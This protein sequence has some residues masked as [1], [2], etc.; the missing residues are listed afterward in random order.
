[1]E[2]LRNNLNIDFM[3][4]RRTAMIFSG[5]LILIAIL[6]FI[7]MGFNKGIDFEGGVI[8]VVKFSKSVKVQAVRD[9][10][11]DAD[12]KPRVQQ[13]DSPFDMLIRISPDKK[14]KLELDKNAATQVDAGGVKTKSHALAVMELLRNK[15]DQEVK[16]TRQEEVGPQIG[17]ELRDQGGIAILIALGA[18]LVYVWLRFEKRFALGSIFALMHDVIIVTGVFS[19][20][21][22]EFDLTVLAAI[23]AVIGYS[24]NDT[25]VVF[26]RIREN[27]RKMRKG[28]PVEI[29]N[30]SLNQT[31][32][33]TLMTS[34]TTLLV[35][36]ALISFGPSVIFGFSFALIIG[37][38][39][40]TYSSIYVASITALLMGVNKEDLM[41]VAKE[42]EEFAGGGGPGTYP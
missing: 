4:K 20:F 10:L 16:S 7:F 41:P 38:V 28:T 39:V 35:L 18:I 2:I 9:V 30:R 11:E 42:G 13:L 22:I 32:S 3:G 27:F 5:S 6:S 12:Y 34:A 40:G 21:S 36:I 25:I 19:V 17:E 31:L 24:L 37:I 26:D 33:R 23:L 14:A 1:M 15:I 8:L 29:I